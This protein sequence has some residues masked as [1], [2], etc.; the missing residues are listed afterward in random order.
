MIEI[1]RLIRFFA[2]V[3]GVIVIITPVRLVMQQS[4]RPKG[5][6]NG[7]AAGTRSCLGVLL[8]TIG[9]IAVGILLWQPFPLPVSDSILLMIT[10][11][12]AVFYFPGVGLYLWGLSTLRS[13]FGVSGLL[14]ATLN[15]F[16]LGLYLR[17]K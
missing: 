13:Q 5:R 17:R 14:G 10:L 1:T 2:I 12:G 3:L 8:I 11:A 15:C 4:Q 7:K 16:P 6:T 9:F